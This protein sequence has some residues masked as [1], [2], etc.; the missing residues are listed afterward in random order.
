MIGQNFSPHQLLRTILLSFSFIIDKMH[1]RL[2][3]S[4]INHYFEWQWDSKCHVTEIEVSNLRSLKAITILHSRLIMITSGRKVRSQCE[5]AFCR[6][7]IPAV[8]CERGAALCQRGSSISCLNLVI[9]Y[10]RQPY[11][12]GKKI[13]FSS[14]QHRQSV[15]HN[16]SWLPSTQ[17]CILGVNVTGKKRIG[18]C[19]WR[20]YGA[21]TLWRFRLLTKLLLSHCICLFYH[22][23]THDSPQK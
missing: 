9:F 4:I 21:I 11:L 23:I 20:D 5:M 10:I 1:T 15:C 12:D 22:F 2:A 13:A 17:L 14:V 6:D 18:V 7:N 3:T 16:N 8:R 19:P